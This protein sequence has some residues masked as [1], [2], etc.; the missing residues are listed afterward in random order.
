MSLHLDITHQLGPLT[1]S[2]AFEAGPG[3]TALFGRSGA[4]KTSIVNAVAGLLHPD[5]GRITLNDEVLFDASRHINQAA[6]KRRLGYVFQDTRLFP[7]LDVAANLRFGARYAPAPLSTTEQSRIIDMLGIGPLL[8]RRPL[9]L[10]GGEK[11]RVALGRALFAAPRMLL[12]DEPLAALDDPRKAEILPYFERLRDEAQMPILYVSHA[13][14]EVARLADTLV[15]LNAG[16]VVRAGPLMDVLADPAAVPLVGVRDAGA[17][18]EAV[19]DEHGKD[20]LSRLSISAGALHLPGV[21]APVGSRVRLRVLAQDV[22]LSRARPQGMSTLNV[23]PATIDAVQAGLGPG[24]AVAL[25]AGDDRL[26]ARITS[27]SVAELGL[28]PGMSVYCILQA[29]TVARGN[30][31]S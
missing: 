15:L 25:R 31:G 4:G 28:V 20:G 29:T 14:A 10:S 24:T 9:S 18:I 22:I 6:H 1:L 12:M 27:R 21:A 16:R 8:R 17:V 11:S 26:L 5:A 13:M 2:A 23:I 3:V 19:V 30:I 7:H